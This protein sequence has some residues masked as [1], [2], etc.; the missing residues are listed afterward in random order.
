MADKL[1]KSH[2]QEPKPKEDKTETKEEIKAKVRAKNY[3]TE[4]LIEKYVSTGVMYNNLVEE[5]NNL[6]EEYS[7]LANAVENIKRELMQ[8]LEKNEN[9]LIAQTKP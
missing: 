3:D 7:D 4:T 9:L 2:A 8:L 6:V 5:Y 1:G